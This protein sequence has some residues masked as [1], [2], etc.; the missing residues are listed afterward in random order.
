MKLMI[1]YGALY[2]TILILTFGKVISTTCSTDSDVGGYCWIQYY[3]DNNCSG[4]KTF[5]EGAV[6]GVC[7]NMEHETGQTPLF[8]S[9]KQ[10]YQSGEENLPF[11]W[12]FLLGYH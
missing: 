12:R 3:K 10:S 1:E 7:I 4:T 9:F 5:A 2:I 8:Q 11:F 6:V